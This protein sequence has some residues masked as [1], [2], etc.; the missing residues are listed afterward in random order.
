MKDVFN[1]S[2]IAFQ[3]LVEA[4]LFRF[5][6][7]IVESVGLMNEKLKHEQLIEITAWIRKLISLTQVENQPERHFILQ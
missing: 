4:D 5:N 7:F 3:Y 6:A 2:I 1:V